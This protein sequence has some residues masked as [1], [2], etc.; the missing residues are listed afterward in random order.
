MTGGIAVPQGDADRGCSVVLH[1]FPTALATWR[2]QSAVPSGL[3]TIAS[4]FRLDAATTRQLPGNY[5]ATTRRILSRTTPGGGRRRV[6]AHSETRQ[7]S[8]HVTGTT[9][10]VTCTWGGLSRRRESRR[11]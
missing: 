7:D 3:H 1:A 2:C 6:Y 4:M 10:R 8:R 9:C 5:Q 11:S